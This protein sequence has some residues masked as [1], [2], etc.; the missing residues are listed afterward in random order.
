MQSFFQLQTI[1]GDLSV[2]P[3]F[4]SRTVDSV[5][6]RLRVT[7]AV[8]PSQ[9]LLIVLDE[10]NRF[11]Q[12]MVRT[13]N[14]VLNAG[15]TANDN[16]VTLTG[17]A[18]TDAYTITFALNTAPIGYTVT[19]DPTFVN[20]AEFT[21]SIAIRASVVATRTAANSTTYVMTATLDQPATESVNAVL[22]VQGTN[23]GSGNWNPQPNFNI[24]DSSSTDN[25]TETLSGTVGSNNLQY[26]VN[27]IQHPN[28]PPTA[29][30]VLD[31]QTSIITIPP[32]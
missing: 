11:N 10:T 7:T 26:N 8:A 3:S 13:R 19:I 12:A 14:I 6:Y 22:Q 18:F 31:I 25:I 30:Y 9:Q 1:V 28:F 24:G 32:F 15:Q 27:V 29:G 20:I 21:T 5:T 16:D 17:L 4:V 23:G 2:T